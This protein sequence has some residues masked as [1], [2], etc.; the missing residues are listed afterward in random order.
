MA[1][2]G[3]RSRLTVITDLIIPPTRIKR[4]LKKGMCRVSISAGVGLAAI[5]EYIVT[6]VLEAGNSS[7]KING[8]LTTRQ[9]FLGIQKKEFAMLQDLF[10][11]AQIAKSGVQA[12]GVPLGVRYTKK[13]LKGVRKWA[14]LEN[15]PTTPLTREQADQYD[16]MKKAQQA[17]NR[18]GKKKQEKKS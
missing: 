16:A 8:R 6:K 10:I 12:K 4:F 9:I 7:K 11:Q 17:E 5:L 18:K 15:K 1:A 14:G 2:K 13:E 3:S